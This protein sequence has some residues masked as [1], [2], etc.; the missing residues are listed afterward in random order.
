MIQRLIL[1]WGL[2]ASLALPFAAW[3][4]TAKPAAAVPA[5]PGKETAAVAP[6]ANTKFPLT[7]AAAG[8][9]PLQLTGW[10]TR[11]RFGFEVYQVALYVQEKTA[12]PADY[13][14]LA[15]RV[16]LTLRFMRDL[17]NE[18]F[19][20][21][22]LAALK[23]RV[24]MNESPTMVESTL[25]FSEVFSS[26]PL[27]KAGDEVTLAFAPGGRMEFAINGDSKG[28]SPISELALARGILS[29]FVGAKPIEAELKRD[30]LEGGP[31]PAAVA[32][33]P[34]GPRR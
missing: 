32:K 10:G 12:N 20:R 15:K 3:S 23:E 30:I 11:K 2:A 26:V 31:A 13:L 22:M 21:I 28:F 16:R 14:L 25:K 5:A 4:Q 1:G 17:E 8:G 18:Q 27:F 9:P 6:S 7:V 33:V 19:T 24:S 29:I 34:A